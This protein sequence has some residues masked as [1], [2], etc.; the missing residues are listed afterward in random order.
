MRELAETDPE[1]CNDFAE[2]GATGLPAQVSVTLRGRIDDI[3]M[4]LAAVPEGHTAVR[5]P[6]AEID[7]AN[8]TVAPALKA[9]FGDD[10]DL[11]SSRI[12]PEDA[13]R[14]CEI[15]IATLEAYAGLG[16]ERAA[17]LARSLLAGPPAGETLRTG[18]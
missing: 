6:R 7:A 10:L 2:D 1:A 3:H 11:L 15:R 4:R 13:A 16:T 14:A 9:R 8:A 18:S 17:A 12:A 5:L